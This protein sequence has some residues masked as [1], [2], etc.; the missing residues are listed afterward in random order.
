MEGIFSYMH[1]SNLSKQA[2]R[3]LKDRQSICVTVYNMRGLQKES[4]TTKTPNFTFYMHNKQQLNSKT[5][6][7][8]KKL[9]A[10]D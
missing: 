2:D 7:E 4:R 3:Y 8:Y 10:H 6:T 5:A 9:D 1:F